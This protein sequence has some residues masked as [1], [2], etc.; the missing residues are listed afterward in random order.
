MNPNKKAIIHI[1]A[2]MPDLKKMKLIRGK[3]P[4]N[5]R[6]DF[7][8][9]YGNII[10]VLR[11]NGQVEAITALVQF[12]DPPLR[13]FTFQDFQLA[14]TLEEFEQV[15]GFSKIKEGPYTEIG[16]VIKVEDLAKALGIPFADLILNYKAEGEVQGIKRQYLESKAPSFAD[17]GEWEPCGDILALLIFSLVLFPN[18]AD[19]ID[20]LAIGVFWDVKVLNKDPTP[21]LHADLYYTLHVQH[22][23]GGGVLQCCIPLLYSWLLSH[24][25]KESYMIKDLTRDEWSQKLKALT[26]DSVV[27]CPN[28]L[29]VKEI[30]FNCGDFPNVPLLGL[31]AVL[32]TTPLWLYVNLDIL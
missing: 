10:D 9:R 1:G 22:E 15:L 16:Q 12:C 5:A 11:M 13:C 25:G 28:K 24:L 26:A 14:P 31:E 23:K 2:L 27:W 17:K 29:E 4:D 8:C 6:E 21:T 3:L 32:T 30:I 7:I 18:T 19:F 20:S